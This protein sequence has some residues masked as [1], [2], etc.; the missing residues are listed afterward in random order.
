YSQPGLRSPHEA[1][2]S[3]VRGATDYSEEL[4]PRQGEDLLLQD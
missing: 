1:Q 3:F 2:G 4:S